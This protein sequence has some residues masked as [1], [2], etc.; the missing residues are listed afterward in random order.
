MIRRIG[1]AFWL[2]LLLSVLT[3]LSAF[4]KG[5]YA[6][7]V[8][9]GA[10]LKNTVKV[11]DPALTKDFFAFATF[12]E[13]KTDPP[14]EAGRGY[15]ITRYYIDQNREVAFD[16]LHYYP[17]EGLVFYDGIAGGGSSEYDGKW[18]TAKPEIKPVFEN[19]LRAQSNG[20]P[21]TFVSFGNALLFAL[22]GFAAV[23]GY[24]I[25]RR[26]LIVT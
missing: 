2:A 22:A 15:E 11:T 23:G 25:W 8:I 5:S 21:G 24:L 1:Y 26:R 19:V 6:F 17:D 3:S 13:A 18:Y 16:R 20:E 9:S 14:T 10:G 4:A 7:I 12:Y